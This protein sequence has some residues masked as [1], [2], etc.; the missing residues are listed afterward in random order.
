[1]QIYS[2]DGSTY[3]GE[4]FCNGSDSGALTVPSSAFSGMPNGALLAV[5][6]YRFEQASGVSPLDGSTIEGFST[7]GGLGTG[8]LRP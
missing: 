5:Y 7:F 4:V 8:T 2:S 1:M 3:M 6:L